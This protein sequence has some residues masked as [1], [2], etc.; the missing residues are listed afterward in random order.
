MHTISENELHTVQLPELTTKPK[1]YK[2][3]FTKDDNPDLA[4]NTATIYT[5]SRRDYVY[6]RKEIAELF[7]EFVAF[8][9]P[10]ILGEEGFMNKYNERFQ[11]LL[12]SSEPENEVY[13]VPVTMTP[14]G[15]IVP[16]GMVQFV[17]KTDYQRAGMKM[18]WAG[19]LCFYFGNWELKNYF[20]D[21]QGRIGE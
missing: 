17:S 6:L 4:D 20:L 7:G 3:T 18:S 8:L 11:E 9:H 10:R 12:D 16:T 14:T 21:Y 13:I 19:E 1:L 2:Y 5:C 15:D